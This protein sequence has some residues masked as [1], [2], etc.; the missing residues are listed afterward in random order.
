MVTSCGG[1]IAS[2][3]FDTSGMR[4]SE[5][6]P[7]IAVVLAL[8]FCLRASQDD[9]CD[10]TS[11][12]PPIR[13]ASNLAGSW[14]TPFKVWTSARLSA[15]KIINERLLIRSGAELPQGLGPYE[16]YP[17]NSL[18]Q[19][20]YS[21]CAVRDWPSLDVPAQIAYSVFSKALSCTIELPSDEKC[22]KNSKGSQIPKLCDC[23]TA[24]GVT[25]TL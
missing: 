5:P 11:K 1:G 10:G 25:G 24:V 6:T 9:K 15:A 19:R 12:P 18:L 22:D 8:C 2:A 23:G 13:Q 3:W 21:V 4:G 17:L 16:S 7:G 14:F 20:L